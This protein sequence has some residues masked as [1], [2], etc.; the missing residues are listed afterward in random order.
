MPGKGRWRSSRSRPAR[1]RS[2]ERRGLL[3]GKTP[4][5]RPG[6]SSALLDRAEFLDIAVRERILGQLETVGIVIATAA[7]HRVGAKRGEGRRIGIVGAIV[8]VIVAAAA[9]DAILALAAEQ[10]VVAAEAV[11]GIAADMHKAKA[12]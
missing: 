4:H 5:P 1:Q 9:V 7:D 3:T 12:E 11:E 8:E 10:A 6:A 2:R